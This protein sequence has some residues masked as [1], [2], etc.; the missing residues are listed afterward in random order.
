MWKIYLVFI[1]RGT[2]ENDSRPHNMHIR[3]FYAVLLF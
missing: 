2:L 1:G 3:V